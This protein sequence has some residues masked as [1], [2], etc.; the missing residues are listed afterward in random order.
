MKIAND[1]W[2]NE[3][4]GGSQY[5]F[6]SSHLNDLISYVCSNR[7]PEFYM[8]EHEAPIFDSTVIINIYHPNAPDTLRLY[9]YQDENGYWWPYA[10]LDC[11]TDV[12]SLL[13]SM[14]VR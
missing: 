11:L 9:L 2:F 3:E 14:W 4:I 12:K 13:K 6:T 1:F 5:G 8:L 10:T 7:D